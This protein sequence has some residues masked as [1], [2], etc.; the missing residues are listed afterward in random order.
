MKAPSVSQ[1]SA[2]IGGNSVDFKGWLLSSKG[3]LVFFGCAV[4]LPRELLLTWHAGK[5]SSFISHVSNKPLESDW[6]NLLSVA[7]KADRSY[8]S[9]LA[10]PD[11]YRLRL[12]VG[13]KGDIESKHTWVLSHGEPQSAKLL[14]KPIGSKTCCPSRKAFIAF[15]FCFCFN[16]KMPS[17]SDQ[18]ATSIAPM[19]LR[20]YLRKYVLFIRFI[21][22]SIIK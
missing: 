15:F 13:A 6:L 21:N 17:R 20:L 7:L 8:F 10:K 11:H 5:S 12:P 3:Q 1:L 2:V 9:L 4:F 14:P 16:V 19:L 18:T 22:K